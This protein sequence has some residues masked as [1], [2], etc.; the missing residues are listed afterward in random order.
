[1]EFK[2]NKLVVFH[3]IK[4]GIGVAKGAGGLGHAATL[5]D[6]F[7]ENILKHLI[8]FFL[9]VTFF[10]FGLIIMYNLDHNMKLHLFHLWY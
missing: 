10:T 3:S 2:K 8:V 9:E 1:L 7:S 4:M 6:F 5:S